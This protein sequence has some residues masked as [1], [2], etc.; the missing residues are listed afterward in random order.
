MTLEL[1]CISDYPL[2]EEYHQRAIEENLIQQQSLFELRLNQPISHHRIIEGAG[3]YE[4]SIKPDSVLIDVKTPVKD[5]LYNLISKDGLESLPE[6][7]RSQ[8]ISYFTQKLGEI[9]GFPRVCRLLTEAGIDG[10]YDED[11]NNILITNLALIS[12]EK[13]RE[14]FK[15]L[16]KPKQK[17]KCIPSGYMDIWYDSARP[18]F[19]GND[20]KRQLEKLK[21]KV[22]LLDPTLSQ[23]FVCDTKEQ[24]A[25]SG[26][27]LECWR[28]DCSEDNTHIYVKSREGWDPGLIVESTALEILNRLGA[29]TPETDLSADENETKLIIQNIQGIPFNQV[30]SQSDYRRRYEL[31]R[32]HAK[33]TAKHILIGN[34]DGGSI[35]AKNSIV[36]EDLICPIDPVAMDWTHDGKRRSEDRYAP[37]GWEESVEDFFTYRHKKRGSRNYRPSDILDKSNRAFLTELT[38]IEKHLSS[39]EELV[40]DGRISNEDFATLKKRFNMSHERFQSLCEFP[41][42]KR[43]ITLHAE[44][45]QRLKN[46]NRIYQ[47]QSPS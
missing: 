26:I 3:V 15:E 42:T 19:H 37:F 34:Y 27:S 10:I 33:D 47:S 46:E 9:I 22:Q 13:A 25:T 16:K 23:D 28:N 29:K 4:C 35:H 38:A 17:R 1:Y 20:I 45:H 39:L 5:D 44:V 43:G 31:R 32:L 8:G 11:K 30:Y 24:R 36:L 6:V 2:G 21:G 12:D 40:E 14:R 18:A 7:D 41:D